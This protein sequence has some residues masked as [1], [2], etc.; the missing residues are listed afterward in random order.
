VLKQAR[1]LE[2]QAKDKSSKAEAALEAFVAQIEQIE[3]RFQ[4]PWPRG[5][6]SQ[7]ILNAGMG[8]VAQFGPVQGAIDGG[9]GP[10]NQGDKLRAREVEALC[11]QV[12][13]DANAAMST[14]IPKINA[15]L[16]TA[17]ISPAIAR[18][19]GVAAPPAES[20][21]DDDL[22]RSETDQD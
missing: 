20:A 22:K 15:V 5:P 17:G 9:E 18:H 2:K 6:G 12:R 14:A 7:M 3:H 13:A 19:P 21:G 10:I 1:D 8:P 4:P 16:G 11:V